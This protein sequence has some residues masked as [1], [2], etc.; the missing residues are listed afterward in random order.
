MSNK[1]IKRVEEMPVY[2]LFFQ[3]AIDVER[4]SREFGRDFMWLRIQM[5]KSSE[6]PTANM[7]E[8]FYSQYTTEYRQSLYRCRREARE[9]QSQATSTD[10][11]GRYEEALSQHSALIASI[12]RK[13]K[14]RGKSRPEVRE[15]TEPYEIVEPSTM[16]H[17][18]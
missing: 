2:R 11:Y 9:T 15:S 16:N 13:L 10:L 18:P 3:L 7:T 14:E 5:L 17:Q 8:G 6:S 1:K 4:V 12:E